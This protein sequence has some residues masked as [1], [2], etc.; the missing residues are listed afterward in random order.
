M[1]FP[2]LAALTLVVATAAAPAGAE[3]T[4]PPY[5]YAL[6]TASAEHGLI[7]GAYAQTTVLRPLEHPTY[8]IAADGLVGNSYPAPA[9]RVLATALIDIARAAV[10]DPD[11]AACIRIHALAADGRPA[12]PNNQEGGGPV[13][14][15]F[16]AAP[17]P[18]SADPP[19][20]LRIRTFADLATERTLVGAEVYTGRYSHPL[21]DGAVGAAVR[22][23][24]IGFGPAAD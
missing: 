24:E 12:L 7:G 9:G 22:V 19:R 18:A 14:E 3:P 11:G 16:D 2:G 21:E 5:D 13:C 6:G 20:L 8:A 15:R 1:R 10:A 23:L 4:G 17:N